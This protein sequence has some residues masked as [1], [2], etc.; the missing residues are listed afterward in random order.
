MKNIDV[1]RLYDAIDV[2]ISVLILE[3]SIPQA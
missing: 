1:I 2:G 3:E